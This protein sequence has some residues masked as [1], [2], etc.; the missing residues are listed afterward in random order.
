M[1]TE[2]EKFKIIYMRL[3]GSIVEV[4]ITAIDYE[5]AMQMAEHFDDVDIEYY[6]LIYIQRI[7]Y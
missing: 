4:C 3:D 5:Q 2:D 1:H 7:F 6:T